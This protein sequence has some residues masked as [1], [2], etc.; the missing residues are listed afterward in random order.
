[1]A[2]RCV[3]NR[4]DRFPNLK[5]TLEKQNETTGKWE[6]VDLTEATIIKL[7]M[8]YS[9]IEIEGT[10]TV[11]SPKTLGIVEYE[12]ASEDTEVAGGYRAQVE[13]T[14]TNGKPQTFPNSGYF[15]IDIQPDLAGDA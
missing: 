12:W 6:P 14:W 13:V 11:P 2:N 7:Y 10:C 4:G 3:I 9:T 15:P 1:M 5:L 8:V